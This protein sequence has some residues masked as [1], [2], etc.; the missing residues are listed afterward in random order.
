METGIRE[1]ERS[2]INKSF[3]QMNKTWPF[4]LGTPISLMSKSRSLKELI[5]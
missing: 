3:K 2:F 5:K 4:D 1:L